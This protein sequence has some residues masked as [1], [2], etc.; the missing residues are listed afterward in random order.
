MSNHCFL[1]RMLIGRLSK[2]RTSSM[3]IEGIPS[4]SGQK[5]TPESIELHGLRWMAPTS[6]WRK[7]PIPRELSSPRSSLFHS[8]LALDSRTT[9]CDERKYP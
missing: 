9:I 2:A 1:S 4:S 6:P 3:I 5:N 8:S 7:A